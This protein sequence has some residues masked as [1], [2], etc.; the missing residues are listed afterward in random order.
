MITKALI[1]KLKSPSPTL[2]RVSS[3]T[4]PRPAKLCNILFTMMLSND[5]NFFVAIWRLLTATNLSSL[6]RSGGG[7]II[8][9]VDEILSHDPNAAGL[10]I[11]WQ[12]FG[13]NGQEE[14]DYSRGVLERFTSRS[15]NGNKYIKTVANPRNISFFHDPH[16]PN[17]F[18]GFY[19]VDETLKPVTGSIPVPI[20]FDKIVVNHYHSKS[21]EEYAKKVE[22]GNAD[23]A[24]NR[25]S[26]KNFSHDKDNDEFDD[27][28]LKYREARAKVYQPPDKSR[29]DE[30]LF[31]A[32]AE[33]LFPTLLPTTPPEFYAGKMETFLTCR[34]VASYLQ[35][36]F[37]DEAP[38]KFFEEAAIKA[39]LNTLQSG[40]SLADMR[41]LLSEL[42]ELLMLS[43]PVV[44]KLREAC[45]QIVPQMMNVMRLNNSWFNY[46]E[47]D[48]IL[49]LLKLL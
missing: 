1:I 3:I 28:I 16:F 11:H 41:L 40:T 46:V 9:I 42:P 18:E 22:R 17:Y 21:K 2:K 19:S 26:M 25:Y 15:F 33:N 27:S 35:T 48:Y 29:A 32:L 34:A 49:R 20:S 12:F 36:K 43:Y 7:C 45:L 13:S 44:K 4:F 6:R 37:A 24:D 38:A 14:A 5:S 8:D 23:F 39:I 47:L 10:A 30:R 31:N